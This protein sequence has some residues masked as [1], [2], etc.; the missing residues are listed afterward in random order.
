MKQNHRSMTCVLL[1]VFLAGASLGAEVVFTEDG[2]IVIGTI[3]KS[4]EGLSTYQSLGGE[5]V[6]ES[7]RIV[8]SESSAES[9]TALPVIVELMDGSV[10]R[11]KIVDFDPDIGIFLDISFGVL[12]IPSASVGSIVEPIQNRRYAGSPFGARLGASW[13]LPVGGLAADFSSA[14]RIEATASY[15]LPRLRGLAAGLDLSY[16]FADFTARSDVDYGFIALEP[17]VSWHYLDWRTKSSFAKVFAP[18]AELGL[19]PV[20]VEV[21]DTSG[22]LDKLGEIC[23]GTFA[24]LGC[25]LDLFSG[26]GLR[27]QARFDAFFQ[28]GQPFMAVSVGILGGF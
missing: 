19:G 16:S 28:K 25:D 13:Y 6:L 10:L 22:T 7:S 23:L 3:V 2:R 11:G 24:K 4:E 1:L 17:L 18:F 15:S 9:L 12:T 5:V 8:R 14:L 26:F 20:Y 27:A 21:D